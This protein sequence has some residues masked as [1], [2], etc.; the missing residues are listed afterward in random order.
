MEPDGCTEGLLGL[1][2][3][4]N[5]KVCP[6]TVP[7]PIKVPPIPGDGEEEVLEVA[8]EVLEVG[9]ALERQVSHLGA[10]TL[11]MFLHKRTEDVS[12]V[13]NGDIS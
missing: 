13:G 3:H 8:V 11:V 4:F 2:G 6:P 5:R 7:C 12:I 9:V 10:Q 1:K